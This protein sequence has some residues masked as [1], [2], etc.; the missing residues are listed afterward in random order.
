MQLSVE[1]RAYSPERRRYRRYAAAELGCRTVWLDESATEDIRL[2][3]IS[4]GGMCLET[5]R[6]LREGQQES[7]RVW[8]Q[9]PMG[10]A[11]VRSVVRWI[12]PANGKFIVGVEFLESD[13]GWLGPEQEESRSGGLER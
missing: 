6:P 8:M 5:S 4:A 11:V 1:S 9:P 2:V 3:N 12:R 10:A 7:F 13:K